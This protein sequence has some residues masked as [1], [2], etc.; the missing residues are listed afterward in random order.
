MPQ[1]LLRIFRNIKGD[2]TIWVVVFFLSIF[3]LLAVYS[4]TGT[5]AYKNQ[6]G[7]T[8]YYLI[9]HGI[10]LL[11]GLG[12]LYLA[13]MVKYTYY[14]RIG[15]LAI[16][17]AVPLLLATLIIG[18]DINNARRVLQLPGG[19]TFQT[20]DLA[21]LALIMYL[22]RMLTKKQADIGDFKKA[23]LPVLIPVL[24]VCFL[25]LPANFSTAAMLLATSV[26]LMFIG[27]V[28][29]RHLL[30]LGASFI[31][32]LFLMVMV[33]K[34]FPNL[35]PRIDT[36]V[37]RVENFK[38]GDGEESYQVEQAKIA[39]ANGGI[40]GRMPGNS[41]QRN[42]LPH[43]YSDFIFA[44]II[45][46]YGLAGAFILIMLYLVLLFRA[47]RISARAPNHF[48]AL[49]SIGVA[50]NLVFQAMVNMGVAVDLL[51][52]TGQP[53]PLVSMGGTSVWFTA[54][55]IGIILS[56]SKEVEY[57]KKEGKTVEEAA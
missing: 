36:W 19:L 17:I 15:Q 13:H 54:I 31:L 11:F 43:P 32:L 55:S 50:L 7:N 9:K 56:V 4:S 8:E 22:A 44:I 37:S 16:F 53:L 25:I 33:S 18:A 41:K 35:L 23:F 14:S 46:E 30:L 47:I 5:L 21:K 40:V 26:V 3:S 27:G 12:F 57:R 28:K 2:R 6:G 52:V 20:S 42:F 48:G 10:I 49:L 24:I 38:S 45:E 34:A 51:P 1:P 39:I 29:I